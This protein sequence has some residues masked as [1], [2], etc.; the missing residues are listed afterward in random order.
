MCPGKV[1]N[2]N[3]FTSPTLYCIQVVS[4]STV[5]RSVKRDLSRM[6][7]EAVEGVENDKLGFKFFKVDRISKIRE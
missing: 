5:I 7:L 2:S 6:G 4:G 1:L 3:L